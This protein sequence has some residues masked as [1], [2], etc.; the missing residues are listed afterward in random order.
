MERAVIYTWP[1]VRSFHLAIATAVE[2]GRFS[3][4]TSETIRERAQ[5]FFSRQDLLT[6][7]RPT[8]SQRQIRRPRYHGETGRK[9]KPYVE[10]GI[11]RGNVPALLPRH[12]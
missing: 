3:L 5:T 9:R 12:L 8:G 1:S 10:I 11:T 7:P 2:Q 6:Q 4:T